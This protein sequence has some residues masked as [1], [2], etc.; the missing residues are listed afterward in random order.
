MS[1]NVLYMH[2]WIYLVRFKALKTHIELLEYDVATMLFTKYDQEYKAVLPE[3]IDSKLQT[4]FLIASCL[5]SL[6]LWD[7][8][9]ETIK[10]LISYLITYR[11]GQLCFMKRL[12]GACD[13][14][15]GSLSVLPA[16]CR[17]MIAE[18]VLDEVM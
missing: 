9:L 13:E 3:N 15:I 10:Y 8:C 2:S 4:N 18:F 14:A 6:E 7:V 12:I 17:N 16:D 5:A 11:T 1:S